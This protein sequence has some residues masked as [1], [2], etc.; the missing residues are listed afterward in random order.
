MA[1]TCVITRATKQMQENDFGARRS[2]DV[3]ANLAGRWRN[4]LD[5]ERLAAED[6]RPQRQDDRRHLQLRHAGPPLNTTLRVK[7]SA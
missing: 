4:L 1:A 3:A 7:Y 5:D 2:G 6:S